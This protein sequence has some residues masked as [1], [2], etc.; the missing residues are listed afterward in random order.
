MHVIYTDLGLLTYEASTASQASDTM[1]VL[2]NLYLEPKK[3]EMNANQSFEA[4]NQQSE[5][6]DV[7]KSACAILENILNSYDGIP[8]E[9]LLG[10]ISVLFQ[11]LG[12]HCLLLLYHAIIFYCDT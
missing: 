10:V 2:I 5:E 3:V 9:H 8:N 7:I 4:V 11:K 6:A 12:T 1:K